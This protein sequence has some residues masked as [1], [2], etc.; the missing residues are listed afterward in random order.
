M[1]ATNITNYQYK[2]ADWLQ[3]FEKQIHEEIKKARAV[4]L[5]ETRLIVH[6]EKNRKD[7]TNSWIWVIVSADP[8]ILAVYFHYAPYRNGTNLMIYEERIT[9]DLFKQTHFQYLQR[10]VE[11]SNTLRY[12]ASPLVDDN[13]LEL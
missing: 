10:S 7:E 12:F 5:D 1:N 2:I 4:N 11:N 6:L 9:K 3:G 8:K 13:S